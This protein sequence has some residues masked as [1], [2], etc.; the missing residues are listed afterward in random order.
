MPLLRRVV[1]LTVLAGL[2]GLLGACGSTE[3]RVPTTLS[4]NTGTLSFTAIGDQQQLTPTITDQDGNAL[5]AETASWSSSDPTV[6]SVS[7]TGLVTAVGSGSAEI[8][9]A[10]G[11]VTAAAQ[12]SVTQTPAQIQKISGDGQSG[13]AGGTLADPL[14]VQVNDSRGNP[15]QNATVLFTVV[16]G[17]GSTSSS[18]AQTGSD[19]RASIAFTTGTISGSAQVV[20]ATIQA[21]TLSVT[22]TAVAAADP[23]AFNI[24]IRYLSSATPTQRQAFNDARIRWEG[25]ISQDIEDGLLNA[26]ASTCGANSPAVNQVIDDLLILVEL[27]PIDGAGGVLGGA[28]PCWIR[29]PSNLTIM[30]TMQFDTAD[31]EALETDGFLSNVILH[32][33]GHVLGFGTLWEVDGLL[34]D[35]VGDPPASGADPHFIGSQGL[36]AF[37]DAGGVVYVASAKVPVENIGGPGTADGH[38]RES[39]FDSELMT[40]FIGAGS[41]PLSAVTIASLA[42]LG[43]SVDLTTADPFTLLLSL[44]TF[45]SRP[46]LRLQNDILRG[47][48]HKV[49]S[50]GRVTGQIRR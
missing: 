36:T 47:P 6:A 15:I 12:A 45:T 22:F 16:Q 14:V 21:T 34:V 46:M 40:G 13:P 5:P 32:E 19:G 11:S 18:T 38:W 28:G 31:L 3:P 29:D 43:Y 42:D 39:V 4:L 1:P 37:D 17:D 33:M 49:D 7:P 25:V 27:V 26:P 10:A 48:I 44:R 2:L 20:S 30:G 8:T 24:G 23:A 41:S 35:P 50:R 9:A